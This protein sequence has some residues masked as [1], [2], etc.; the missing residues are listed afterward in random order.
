MFLEQPHP[1]YRTEGKVL[2][3]KI[4]EWWG[5]LFFV[6]EAGEWEWV[7]MG[8]RNF[9]CPS[10]CGDWEAQLGLAGGFAILGG[11]QEREHVGEVEFSSFGISFGESAVISYLFV[12][13]WEPP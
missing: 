11:S 8:R 4:K 9:L 3:W 13:D 6:C 7:G 1:L 10:V 2:E 5:T 12:I